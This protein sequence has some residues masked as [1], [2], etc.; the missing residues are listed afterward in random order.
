M[1]RLFLILI[2]LLCEFPAYG[3]PL[4][5]V[6]S[7]ISFVNYEISKVDKNIHDAESEIQKIQYEIQRV[8]QEIARV[9]LELTRIDSDKVKAQ[10]A[11]SSV[12]S[13]ISGMNDKIGKINSSKNRYVEDEKIFK[14]E[15]KEW[16]AR[17]LE[18]KNEISEILKKIHKLELSIDVKS[19][20]KASLEEMH[21]EI[22]S[23][24]YSEARVQENHHRI[25]DDFSKIQDLHRQWISSFKDLMNNFAPNFSKIQ[26]M[27]VYKQA[28]ANLLKFRQRVLSLN[29]FKSEDDHLQQKIKDQLELIRKNQALLRE[30]ISNPGFTVFSVYQNDSSFL[31][32]LKRFDET[33]DAYYHHLYKMSSLLKEERKKRDYLLEA[34]PSLW[35]RLI[36]ANLLVASVELGVELTKSAAVGLRGDEIIYG[37]LKSSFEERQEQFRESLYVYF[38]PFH[39][40]SVAFE[41]REFLRINEARIK[42]IDLSEDLRRYI[43]ALIGKYRDLF[44]NNIKEAQ[45]VSNDPKDYFKERKRVTVLYTKRYSHKFS[46]HCQNLSQR[47]LKYTTNTLQSESDYK[48]FR[49]QCP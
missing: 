45:K 2:F 40:R 31:E 3:D 48:E 43:D 33:L 26:D 6:N 1:H 18:A 49:S 21:K 30:F 13:D 22:F 7:A 24:N 25:S 29:S 34:V 9:G 46:E 36:K 41:A 19:K 38:M 8:R 15:H 23:L 47:I 39:A 12:R 44:E 35:S 27:K 14:A 37:Q 5:E 16:E 11:L 20:E 17:K 28:E 4:S 32:N 42:K 10:A